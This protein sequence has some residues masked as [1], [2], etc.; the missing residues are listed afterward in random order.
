MI[1]MQ[2]PFSHASG[3]SVT[4]VPS[5]LQA[6]AVDHTQY[7]RVQNFFSKNMVE[8]S[9]QNTVLSQ[10]LWR[11]W[12]DTNGWMSTAMKEQSMLC[13]QFHPKKVPKRIAVYNS[14]P[15]SWPQFL[16]GIGPTMCPP[17]P[18]C[19]VKKMDMLNFDLLL[20]PVLCVYFYMHTLLYHCV[21][22][23]LCSSSY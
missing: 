7:Y 12:S 18:I 5:S 4:Q 9:I 11:C 20:L 13:N 8:N 17:S 22:S 3:A 19:T 10:T 6:I 2:L 1:Q 21:Q 23:Y 16:P 15:K 14:V